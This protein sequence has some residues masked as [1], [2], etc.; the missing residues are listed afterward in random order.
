MT[1]RPLAGISIRSYVLTVNQGLRTS[2]DFVHTKTDENGRYRLTGMPKLAGNLILAL[3]DQHLPYLPILASA[4][5]SPAL[6]AVQVDIS[7]KTGIWIAGRL[8]DKATGKPIKGIVEYFASAKNP[9]SR[10][11]PGYD[12]VVMMGSRQTGEDG[13]YKVLGLPGPGFVVGYRQAGKQFYLEALERDDEFSIK[14]PPPSTAPYQLFPL[15]N[16]GAFARID[17]ATD[18]TRAIRDLTL[19]PG[20]TFNGQVGPDRKPIS[21]ATAY[22]PIEQKTSGAAEFVVH[23]YNPAH[24]P[25]LFF[26]K[27][28]Q[29]G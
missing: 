1:G 24:P 26:L 5:E 13:S 11:H 10:D 28:E 27:S 3:P 22:G 9:E 25:D 23:A 16:Y 6:D 15:S 12:G 29:G 8:T 7:L 19:D 2:F 21:G 17:P 18:S 20:W 4:P 14:Q